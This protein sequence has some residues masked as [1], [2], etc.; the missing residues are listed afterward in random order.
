MI[1]TYFL[2]YYRTKHPNL[3]PGNVTL[4]ESKQPRVP[5]LLAAWAARPSLVEQKVE[6]WPH[7]ALAG[8]IATPGGPFPRLREDGSIVRTERVY[9][10]C[11]WRGFLLSR[12]PLGAGG[13][14][15]TPQFCVFQSLTRRE[16][17]Q[18]GPMGSQAI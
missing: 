12:A 15:T 8:P 17:R 14:R 5:L 10:E 1:F 3:N 16:A 7:S 13:A 18:V 4:C 9:A 11:P 6:T 2:P